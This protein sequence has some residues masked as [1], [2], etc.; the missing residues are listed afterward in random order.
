MKQFDVVANS[1]PRSRGRRPYLVSLQSDL[2][3]HSIDTTI[4]APLERA[5]RATYAARLNP[6]IEFDGQSYFLIAQ[7]LVTVRKNGPGEPR[8]SVAGNRDAIIAALDVLF[9]GV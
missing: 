9:T 6:P 5:G 4:V 1:S 7:Q 2:L 8:G 3:S